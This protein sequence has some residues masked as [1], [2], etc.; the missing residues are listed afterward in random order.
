MMFELFRH[1]NQKLPFLESILRMSFIRAGGKSMGVSY[2]TVT[3]V[4]NLQEGS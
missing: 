2:Y 3:A 1:S 4:G